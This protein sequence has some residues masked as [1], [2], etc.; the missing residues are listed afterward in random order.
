MGERNGA[1]RVLMGKPEGDS[2]E[3]DLGVRIILRWIFGKWDEGTWTGLIW[4]R[5][6]TV[7]GH[8]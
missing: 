1:Y 8:L 5:I 7:G 2:L 6:G 4:L 3:D